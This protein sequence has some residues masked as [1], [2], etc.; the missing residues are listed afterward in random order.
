[1][2]RTDSAMKIKV[3]ADASGVKKGMKD[4][5]AAVKSFDKSSSNALS[6][7]A[8]ALGVNVGK[9]GEMSQAFSGA[10]ASIAKNAGASKEA[11]VGMSQAWASVGTV[12]GGVAAGVLLAWK[13]VQGAADHYAATLE[14]IASAEAS[15]AYSQTYANYM[16]DTASS[17]GKQNF[18]Q[19]VREWGGRAKSNVG[20]YL[21]N[22]FDSSVSFPLIETV[23]ASKQAKG[24]AEEARKIQQGVAEAMLRQK[25]TQVQVHDIQI[26]INEEMGIFR[27]TSRSIEERQASLARLQDLIHTKYEIQKNDAR[28]IANGIRDINNLSST[29]LKDKEAEIAAEIA[30]KDILAGEK[31]ELSALV[32]YSNG[33]NRGPSSS[34]GKGKATAAEDVF[35]PMDISGRMAQFAEDIKRHLASNEAQQ[36]L[37]SSIQE[38]FKDMKPV[39]I[40]IEVRPLVQINGEEVTDMIKDFAMDTLSS[41]GNAIGGALMGENGA[42]ANFGSEMLNGLGAFAQ[43]F[44]GLLVAMGTA[45]LALKNF[46]LN[47]TAAIAAGAALIIAGAAVS[48]MASSLGGGSY[49]AASVGSGYSPGGTAY[50]S[51]MSTRELNVSVSGR[52]VASGSQL[53]AVLDSENERKNHTT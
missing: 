5:E 23:K 37:T 22:Y 21:T 15:R 9:I 13:S 12:A 52:L 2:A 36:T 49:S 25:N 32:R 46:Y 41:F 38:G 8:S 34:S 48:H 53:V 7:L 42:F 1:M 51:D 26:S 18:V 24:V 40:D 10:A 4:A 19:S 27:D 14:G 39:P 17:A 20:T 11:I 35:V 16:M 31:R 50:G 45:G 43:K 30:Y 33:I 3:D 6:S 29:T 47:P 44:G 28:I